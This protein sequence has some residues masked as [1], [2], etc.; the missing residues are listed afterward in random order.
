MAQVNLWPSFSTSAVI[1]LETGSK[2]V[3]FRVVHPDW[4][5]SWAFGKSYVGKHNMDP[6]VRQ[7]EKSTN[8]Q[9]NDGDLVDGIERF[10]VM[11]RCEHSDSHEPVRV[12]I[13]SDVGLVERE[14]VGRKGTGLV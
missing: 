7:R 13:R 14:L 5:F 4:R 6:R 12:D 11:R 3:N 9:S 2:G 10:D 8:L 1:R